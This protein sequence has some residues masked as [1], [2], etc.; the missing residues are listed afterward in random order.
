L[1]ICG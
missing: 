1:V